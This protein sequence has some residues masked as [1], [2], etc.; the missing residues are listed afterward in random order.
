MIFISDLSK[1]IGQF[2]F[3]CAELKIDSGEIIGICGASGSGKTIFAALLGGVLKSDFG[4]IEIDGIDICKQKVPGKNV[5]FVSYR[6]ITYHQ[7]TVAAYLDFFKSAFKMN[8]EEMKAKLN[9]FHEYFP[10]KNYL[11]KKISTLSDGEIQILKVF[12]S[13]INS[14][15][16]LILDEPFS[17]LG[18]DSALQLIRLFLEL[19]AK[20]V[21]V[22]VCSNHINYLESLCGRLIVLSK[23]QISSI[24]SSKK[25]KELAETFGKKYEEVVLSYYNG[26]DAVLPFLSAGV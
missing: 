19:S 22:I 7:F 6:D 12:C 5:S 10:V 24:L 21:V 4:S 15:T 3:S 1:K 23:G 26:R 17:S 9:W 8:E 14:P 18:G 20:D 13:L 2:H 16:H 11:E 25:I